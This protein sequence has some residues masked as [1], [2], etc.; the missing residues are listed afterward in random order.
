MLEPQTVNLLSVQKISKDQMTCWA[1]D[2]SRMTNSIQAHLLH[3][4]QPGDE[5]E[6]CLTDAVLRLLRALP[7]SY[8]LA[9]QASSICIHSRVRDA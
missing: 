3:M 2:A 9:A 7:G 1:F 8:L 4:R 6:P 5:S